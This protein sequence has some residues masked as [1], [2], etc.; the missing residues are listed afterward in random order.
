MLVLPAI[1]DLTEAALLKNGLQ[2]AL[3]KGDGLT[4]DASKVSRVTSP[5]LQVLAA[6]TRAFTESGGPALEIAFASEAFR[7]TVSGLGLSPQFGL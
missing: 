5:C 7:D 4:V 1:L 6:A 3:A 2:D